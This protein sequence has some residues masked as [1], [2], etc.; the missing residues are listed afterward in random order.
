MSTVVNECFFSYISFLTMDFL[1]YSEA[2]F[3]SGT[4]MG[5]LFK[6]LDHIVD[7]SIWYDTFTAQ[8]SK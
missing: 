4:D 8:N 3:G 7:A 5:Q 6:T 2:S 1:D